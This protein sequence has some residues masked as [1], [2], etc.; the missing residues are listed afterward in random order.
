MNL[1]TAANP[2]ADDPLVDP[3]LKPQSG[4]VGRAGT[5]GAAGTTSGVTAA[6]SELAAFVG[7]HY[8]RLLRLAWLVCRDSGEAL[9]IFMSPLDRFCVYLRSLISRF[10]RNCASTLP[11]LRKVAQ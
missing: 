3:P 2:V 7:E 9:Q 4:T 5:A 1:D 10:P 11:T 6:S 8:D